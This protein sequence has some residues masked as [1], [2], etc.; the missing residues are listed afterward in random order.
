MSDLFFLNIFS[1]LI[2][3]NF[4]QDVIDGDLCEQFPTLPMDLQRKIADELDRTPA[5]ILKKLEEIRNKII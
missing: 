3:S 2:E 4:F 1:L 5:E